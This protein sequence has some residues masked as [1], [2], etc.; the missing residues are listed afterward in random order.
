MATGF[1]L[2]THIWE[3]HTFWTNQFVLPLSCKSFFEKVDCIIFVP[4]K[5]CI[6]YLLPCNIWNLDTPK[7]SFWVLMVL[8]H[9]V[10]LHETY[11]GSCHDKK[12][13]WKQ[14]IIWIVDHLF[15]QAHS[16]GC[17]SYVSL[18]WTESFH[19]VLIQKKHGSNP[20]FPG[21]LGFITTWQEFN[22]HHAITESTLKAH[23]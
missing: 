23:Y 7:G 2:N 17:V 16:M 8:L 12:E 19:L 1:H 13:P 3:S 5:L 10:M 4:S 18:C 6:C 11:N 20:I 14:S 9:A 15:S 22:R 21:L